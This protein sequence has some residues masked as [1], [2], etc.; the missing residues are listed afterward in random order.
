MTEL[1]IRDQCRYL[2]DL[3]VKKNHDY[4]D[5]A[6]NPPILLPGLSSDSAIL[7]RMSDKIERIRYLLDSKETPEVNESLE[8]TIRDLAGYCILWLVKNGQKMRKD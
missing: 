4:G 8:D 2:A 3:L 5:S 1:E 7:V 6:D